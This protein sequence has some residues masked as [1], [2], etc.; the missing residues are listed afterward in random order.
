[1]IDIRP[2]LRSLLLSDSTV[3]QMVGGT[4]IYPLQVPQGIVDPSIVY[5]RVSEG[6]NYHMAGDSRVYET[7]MQIDAWANGAS[8]SDQLARAA[9]DVLS[10]FKGVQD[11]VEI[12]GIFMIDG[13]EDYDGVTKMFRKTYD[14]R[15]VYH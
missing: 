10:G 3:S 6:G 9:F 15:M 13:R 4:R 14:Y 7:R 12:Q 8:L 1:M 5:T 2:A 11:G